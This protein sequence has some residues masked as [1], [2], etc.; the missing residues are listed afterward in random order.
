M[1]SRLSGISS[2]SS[3]FTPYACSRKS[4]SCRTP[5]E[6]RIPLSRNDSLSP[7]SSQ[8][9][10]RKFS[11]MNA[12][13]C[14]AICIVICPFPRTGSG[15][16][17]HQVFQQNLRR[18]DAEQSYVV[19]RARRAPALEFGHQSVDA[20]RIK[21]AIPLNLIRREQIIDQFV[22]GAEEAFTVRSAIRHFAPLADDFRD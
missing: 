9:P 1:E 2:S 13:I 20:P 17:L 4:T 14:S 10:K 6:S 22:F 16:V 5:V 15:L 11:A 19:F 7:N 8:G 12:R 3:T 18:Q 21:N